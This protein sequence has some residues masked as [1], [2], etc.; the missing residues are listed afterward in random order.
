MIK[1]CIIQNF[2][3][4]LQREYDN[5]EKCKKLPLILVNY[6]SIERIIV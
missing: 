4:P 3:V 1:N 5:A 6:L 2:F